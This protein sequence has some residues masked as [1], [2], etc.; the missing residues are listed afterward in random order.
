MQVRM[1]TETGWLL[2]QLIIAICDEGFA[3]RTQRINCNIVGRVQSLQ[4][5]V[6]QL[7]YWTLVYYILKFTDSDTVCAAGR[8]ER[9]RT[10]CLW[11]MRKSLYWTSRW[12]HSNW[13][14][15]TQRGNMKRSVHTVT[16]FFSH[17]VMIFSLNYIVFPV[18]IGY[19]IFVVVDLCG[20]LLLTYS[21]LYK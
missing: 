21:N 15:A 2:K 19:V 11:T 7:A 18:F 4:A 20:L 17:S 8:R 14:L 9:W 5:T 1:I 12:G 16:V 13:L 6:M 10:V 3:R